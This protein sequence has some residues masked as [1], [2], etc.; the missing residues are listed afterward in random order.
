MAKTFIISARQ[1]QLIQRNIFDNA[2]IR[3]VA[4]AI[5]TNSAFTVSFTEKHFWYQQ[6]DFRQV[7]ILRRGQLG[8]DFDT[9]NNCRLYLTTM[10]AMSFEDDIPSIPIDDFKDHYA[11]VF[12]LTSMQDVAENCHYPVLV[13]EPL[14]LE[15]NFTQPLENVTELNVLC[16]RNSLV[17]VYKFGVVEK[18][19][20]K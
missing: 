1:I 7:R 3:R 5:N 13:G 20:L 4:I 9:A 14:K 15:L 2:S 11:L 6:F 8:V 17:V 16:E 12:E 18:N 10:N 19:V